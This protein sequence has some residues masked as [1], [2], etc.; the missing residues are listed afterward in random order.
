MLAAAWTNGFECVSSTCDVTTFLKRLESLI[1]AAQI[2][3]GMSPH[4]DELDMDSKLSYDF[5]ASL[6]VQTVAF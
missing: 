3:R 6:T 4:N 5:A 2:A 1:S